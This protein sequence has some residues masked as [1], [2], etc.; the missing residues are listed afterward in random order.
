MQAYIACHPYPSYD[1]M[2]NR[3][4]ECPFLSMEMYAEYGELNH[5]YLKQIYESNFNE[6]LT[7]DL[8][9]KIYERGGL[10]AMQMNCSA[11]Q[12]LGPFVDSIDREVRISGMKKLE[13]LWDGIGGFQY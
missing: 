11:F 2:I 8:G 7:K 5:E 4:E 3:I 12:Y 6:A 9:R 13:F 10:R 1:E